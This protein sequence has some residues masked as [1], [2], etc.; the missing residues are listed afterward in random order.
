MEPE[1]LK[2]RY[3][4]KLVFYGGSYDA[5]ALPASTPAG[6]VRETVARN[7]RALSRGGG[8]IFSGVHN[9]QADV[10]DSHLSAILDAFKEC[11]G[12]SEP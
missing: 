3:G 5:V 9:I 8:Y 11:R 6:T 4:G 10:P 12:D 2:E 7:I 1:A